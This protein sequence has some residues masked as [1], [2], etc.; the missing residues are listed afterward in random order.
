MI[1]VL[2]FMLWRL[3]MDGDITDI[4]NDPEKYF[5]ILHDVTD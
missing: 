5:K 1:E 2:K 4:E 3:K